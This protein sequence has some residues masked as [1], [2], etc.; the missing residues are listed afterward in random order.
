MKKFTTWAYSWQVSSLFW[1]SLRF[2][3]SPTRTI[4]RS[5]NTTSTFNA[6]WTDERTQESE[7]NS[8]PNRLACLYMVKWAPL[9]AAE[10]SKNSKSSSC[11]REREFGSL[12]AFLSAAER[13]SIKSLKVKLAE[14]NSIETQALV[15][16]RNRVSS[17]VLIK[18]AESSTNQRVFNAR[19]SRQWIENQS[20]YFGGRRRASAEFES[21]RIWKWNFVLS[22]LPHRDGKST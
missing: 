2:C 11:Q 13:V 8:S 21:P 9:T 4:T 10:S 1:F 12:K 22:Q 6:V 17:V 3:I 5:E 20:R 14:L 16:Q 18:K 19:D 7:Q 15:F